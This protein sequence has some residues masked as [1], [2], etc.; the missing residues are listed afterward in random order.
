MPGTDDFGLGTGFENAKGAAEVL[1]DFRPRG[2][3]GGAAVKVPVDAALKKAH[4]YHMMRAVLSLFLGFS[5]LSFGQSVISAHSGVVQYVE[6]DVSIDSQPI[7]PKFAQ[8]PDLKPDQ[9]IATEEG[10][11]ELLLTPGVF[12]R[13]PENSSVRMVS[14]SLSDTRLA[15]VSGSALIEVGELLPNNAISFDA[16][17]ARIALTHKGLFRIDS[18][19]ARLRV[20]EGQARVTAAEDVQVVV[21]KGHEAALDSSTLALSTFDTKDTDAFYRWSARR[22]EYVADANITSARVANNPGSTGYVG[23]VGGASP[24]GAWS[25]NP[26]FGMFTYLPG[27]DGMYMS[28]FGYAFYSPIMAT[29]LYIPRMGTLSAGLPGMRPVAPLSSVASMRSSSLGARS[30]GGVRSMGSA[31]GARSAVSA[32]R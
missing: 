12:L 9:V 28:P 11:V 30:M 7:H 2:L 27:G 19:P 6:G 10:R 14:N 5:V 15:V 23:G 25:W 26:W 22:S 17:G 8:F 1:G 18:N 31:G 29:G 32:H 16:A 3:T 21:R 20:Y 24:F 4:D 13:I